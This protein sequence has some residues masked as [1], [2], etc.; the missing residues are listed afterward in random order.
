M[1]KHSDRIIRPDNYP[2]GAPGKGYL[3]WQSQSGVS[4][5]IIN[6]LT[7]VFMN[8]LVECPFR[9]VDSILQSAL[10]NVDFV[11]VDL[12]GEATSEKAAFAYHIDGRAQM[13]VGTHT[14]VQTADE[15]ILPGGL[16][17]ISDAGMC[18]PY[19]S[20]IGVKPE[21]IVE[22]FYS[23]LPTKF[24]TA[25]GTAMINGVVF[26][27]D[28]SQRRVSALERINRVYPS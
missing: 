8:D 7:R 11:F 22:R 2:L 9:A 14:H 6:L 17:F 18:G 20:V 4:V 23:G 27:C 15:R 10:S 19:D 13:L 24:D 21:R 5:G 25:T 12:H 26:R 1:I 16:G 3:I 28:L